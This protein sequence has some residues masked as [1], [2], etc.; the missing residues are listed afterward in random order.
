[1]AH[2]RSGAEIIPVSGLLQECDTSH[3]P[4]FSLAMFGPFRESFGV[5]NPESRP[6][7]KQSAA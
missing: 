6:L 3:V 2:A 1:M 7:D 4:V 5:L